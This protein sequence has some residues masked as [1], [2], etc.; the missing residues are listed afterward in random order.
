MKR[1]V[2]LITCGLFCLA[3]TV[4]CSGTRKEAEKPEV[5]APNPKTHPTSPAAK[6]GIGKLPPPPTPPQ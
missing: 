2:V 5:F 1:L 6:G 4:G 3:L